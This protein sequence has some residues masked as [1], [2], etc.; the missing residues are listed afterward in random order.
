MKRSRISIAEPLIVTFFEQQQQRAYTLAQL[1][2]I[3]SHQRE[4]WQLAKSM[5]SAEIIRGLIQG[6]QLTER[7]VDFLAFS[8]TVYSW[9][10]ANPFEVAMA[11]RPNNFFSHASA[12]YFHKLAPQLNT[13][14]IYINEEQGSKSISKGKLQ[15]QRI[16]AAFARAPRVSKTRV[17]WG[18][19]T[20]CFLNG[21]N[22]GMLG[23]GT[24]I[25]SQEQIAVR[26]TN[27]ERTLIDIAVR[28]AY[29]GG[30]QA[31]LEAYKRAA[32][33]VSLPT[34]ARMLK[35]IGHTYPYHQAIG[36]YLERTG[37]YDEAA[38]AVFRKLP[39]RYDFYLDYQMKNPSYSE[40]WRIYYPSGL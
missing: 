2:T 17:D 24:G 25:L 36:F 1:H 4:A 26:V 7:K 14:V 10:E 33:R 37:C 31:V 20:L 35:K 13:N 22:T 9:G 39:R 19:A 18:Q 27:L 11:L 40:G 32:D 16:D 3:L 29:A 30:P 34:L 23:V 5:S 6:T 15:Q 28:P 21:K 12:M 38:L 8:S